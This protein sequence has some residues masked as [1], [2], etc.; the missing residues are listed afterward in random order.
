MFKKYQVEISLIIGLSVLIL[1]VIFGLPNKV[2]EE[3]MSDIYVSENQER[4]LP[5]IFPGSFFLVR[6]N[7]EQLQQL[8]EGSIHFLYING[9]KLQGE[10]DSRTAEGITPVNISIVGNKKILT[11]QLEKHVMASYFWTPFIR[12]KE[13]RVSIGN[14]LG[15][16]LPQENVNAR[17]RFFPQGSLLFIFLAISATGVIMLMLVRH[18]NMIRDI[19]KMADMNKRSFSLSRAQLAFWTFIVLISAIF[20]FGT[21]RKLID[22][23]N[24]A[25]VLLGI[26]AGT[27]AAGRIIDQSDIVNPRVSKRI[28]DVESKGF[29]LD[30][31]SDRGGISIHRVQT[32]VFNILVGLVFIYEVLQSLE[33][34]EFDNGILFLLGLSSVTYSGIKATE[35]MDP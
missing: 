8:E 33:L 1:Y 5:E 9:L 2:K 32:V 34:P 21:T 27:T 11:F 28:Q 23:T 25:L 7:N 29:I 12:S 24:T 30:I 20:V 18:T 4:H 13:V 17:I 10:E 22:V 26:S 14:E 3:K 35:N 16:V 31:L 19:S 6:L 15:V